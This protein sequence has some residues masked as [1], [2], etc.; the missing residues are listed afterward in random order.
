MG[1]IET[2]F[3]YA[4][5]GLAAA[6]AIA[7]AHGERGLTVAVRFVPRMLLWPFFAPTLFGERFG[8]VTVAAAASRDEDEISILGRQIVTA[9]S[10]LDGVAEEVLAPEVERVRSLVAELS[11]MRRR[12]EE[13]AALRRSSEFDQEKIEA[14]LENLAEGD[15][16]RATLCARMRSVERL[17]AMHERSAIEYERVVLQLEELHSKILLLRF[18]DDPEDEILVLM[19]DISSSVEGVCAGAFDE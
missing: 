4:L 15:P 19:R 10:R 1:L 12:T 2:L 14:S 7:V 13:M 17:R 9:L 5:L 6:S 16:R 11:R 8:P 18:A 3:I